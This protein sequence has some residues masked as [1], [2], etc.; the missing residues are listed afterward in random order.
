MSWQ[1]WYF[2]PQALYFTEEK[3]NRLVSSDGN[4]SWACQTSGHNF[5]HWYPSNTTKV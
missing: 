1:A 2:K 4:N 5:H 3:Q